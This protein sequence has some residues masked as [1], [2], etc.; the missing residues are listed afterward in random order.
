MF[1]TLT[2]AE[3]SIE[4]RLGERT[5]EVWL[6]GVPARS[7][8]VMHSRNAEVDQEG[9]SKE[10]RIFFWFDIAMNDFMFVNM[11]QSAKLE[12]KPLELLAAVG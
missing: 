3:M 7:G 10:T 2:N 5:D 4:A 12:V 6:F 9:P 11:F 8:L 1:Q